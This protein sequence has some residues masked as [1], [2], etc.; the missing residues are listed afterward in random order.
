[1]LKVTETT[2]PYHILNT[3]DRQRPLSQYADN[4]PIFE[5][6]NDAIAEAKAE[7]G[8]DFVFGEDAQ[9]LLFIVDELG[10][11][12]VRVQ[13]LSAQYF[14]RNLLKPET[15]Q[16]RETQFSDAINTLENLKPLFAFFLHLAQ[17]EGILIDLP[18]DD[19]VWAEK[20]AQKIL[21][22][23]RE[24]IEAKEEAAWAILEAFE[25]LCSRPKSPN[26]EDK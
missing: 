25:N 3:Q 19:S 2:M 23:S 21:G 15:E 24:E 4:S 17:H 11:A 20:M 6:L 26:Q 1:M 18:K 16:T 14:I 5:H 10:I 13:W 7:L 8:P 9:V 12:Q 22:R